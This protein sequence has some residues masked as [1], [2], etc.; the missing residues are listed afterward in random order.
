M[1]CLIY[2]YRFCSSTAIT[3]HTTHSTYVQMSIQ[4]KHIRI[5]NTPK[6]HFLSKHTI[7]NHELNNIW[8]LYN[9]NQRKYRKNVSYI[10]NREFIVYGW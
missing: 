9:T 7:Y 8:K 5:Y 6:L 2:G 10:N 4:K 1:T 3:V